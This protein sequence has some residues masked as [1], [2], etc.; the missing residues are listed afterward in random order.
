MTASAPYTSSCLLLW[1]KF[2]TS[3]FSPTTILDLS[4][5][6]PSSR[7]WGKPCTFSSTSHSPSLLE[8][9]PSQPSL[10]WSCCVSFRLPYYP[11]CNSSQFSTL[12][13]FSSRTFF[14]IFHVSLQDEDK[15]GSLP[16]Q[17]VLFTLLLCWNVHSSSYCTEG[18]VAISIP[19]SHG[20]ESPCL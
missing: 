2:S 3:T 13:T 9:V 4:Y 17:L 12:S 14:W 1:L 11:A 10:T 18:A 8:P 20:I 5:S 19:C 15:G 7:L 6:T 16:H